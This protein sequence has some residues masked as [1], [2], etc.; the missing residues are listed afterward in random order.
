MD[1]RDAA[2]LLEQIAAYLE[3]KGENPFR[4]RAYHTASRAVAHL[5]GDLGQLAVLGGEPPRGVGVHPAGAAAI[6]LTPEGPA[7][8]LGH[9]PVVDGHAGLALEL[10]GQRREPLP[11]APP[12]FYLTDG[13]QRREFLE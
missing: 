2:H 11:P 9:R 1:K 7:G 3:L 6:G 8:E 12:R 13:D 10:F 5:P 4:I